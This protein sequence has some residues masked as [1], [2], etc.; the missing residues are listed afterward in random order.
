MVQRRLFALRA[1]VV[2]TLLAG[3]G[4]VVLLR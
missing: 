3:L 1:C 4:L 2:A